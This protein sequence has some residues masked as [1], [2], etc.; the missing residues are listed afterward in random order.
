MRADHAVQWVPATPEYIL[1][2]IQ[3]DWRQCALPEEE[4]RLPTFETTVHEWREAMNLVWWSPLGQALNKSW[5]TRFSEWQ[6]FSVLVPARDMQL[7]GV[8]KLL[9]TKAQRPVVQPVR[10]LG[11]N[12]ASAGVFLAIRSLLV[13]VGASP[14][15]RPSTPLKPFL[16]KWPKVF[17]KEVSRLVPGGLPFGFAGNRFARGFVWS[18]IL[19]GL[20]LAASGILN[21][22]ALIIGGV[23]LFAVGWL[24]GMFGSTWFPAH[25][26]LGNVKT[27]RGLTEMIVKQQRQVSIGPAKA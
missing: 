25:L 14:D 26:T 13:S 20:L 22:P 15:L 10:I 8:C 6:W 16:Q 17:L 19:G 27:F 11:G 4:G 7:R 3:E 12:C 18:A 5:G 21:E 9:A 24:G 2:C 1:A 23:I